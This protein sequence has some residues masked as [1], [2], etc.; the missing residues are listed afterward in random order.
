MGSSVFK[1]HQTSITCLIRSSTSNIFS[2]YEAI[3]LFFALFDSRDG[4]VGMKSVKQL[5][6]G[7][8]TCYKKGERD[9]KNWKVFWAVLLV[10][11]AVKKWSSVFGGK[12]QSV[13]FFDI[14]L[15][16]Q[17]L[18]MIQTHLSDPAPD[19]DH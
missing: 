17:G 18:D 4:W 2:S 13:L 1:F 16:F 19:H 15:F 11:V 9:E 3:L 14:K 10:A 8:I 7:C 5:T 6:L 12:D